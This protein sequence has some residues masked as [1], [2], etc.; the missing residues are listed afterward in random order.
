MLG[1]QQ[2]R[3]APAA[4]SEL[5]KNAHDAYAD[6][7]RAD[8]LRY[9]G[10]LAVRDD[11][12]GMSSADFRER[13]LT[14]GT[15]SR[16]GEQAV[17]LG[18]V[19][20]PILGEKG[21]GRLAIAVLGPQVLVVTR[22]EGSEEVTLSLINWDVFEEPGLNLDEIRFPLL[23]V[24]PSFSETD[25]VGLRDAA[26]E[27][28]LNLR[29]N[30][31]RRAR[32]AAAITAF[33]VDSVELALR[34]PG[35]N[36]R[37]SGGTAFFVSPV[38]PE[39]VDDIDREGETPD[40]VADLIGFANPIDRT[41][42][43]RASFWDWTGPGLK[44]D[45]VGSADFWE[46]AD[47]RDADHEIRGA[48]D[49]N[50]FFRGDIR[51]YTETHDHTIAPPKTVSGRLDCGPFAL[52]LGYMQGKATETKTDPQRFTEL[53]RKLD[54]FN[55]LY[56]YR[57]GIRMLPYG[58]STFD[59]LDIELNRS[60]G[61]SFYFFSYR[62]MFGY[63][64]ITKEANSGLQEK[65][66]REGFR[67][68]RAYRQFR[69]VLKH[70][71]VQ[72]AADYFREGSIGAEPFNKRRDELDR[73]A[74][75]RAAKEKRDAS[76]RKAFA[77]GL[78]GAL[79][80][81]RSGQA[82]RAVAKAVTVG[83]KALADASDEAAA[84]AAFEVAID[85]VASARGANSLGR[86]DVGLSEAALIDWESYLVAFA[87]LE[88]EVASATETLRDAAAAAIAR[89]RAAQPEPNGAAEP[90]V[91]VERIALVRAVGDGIARIRATGTEADAAI[92]RAGRRIR[93]LTDRLAAATEILASSDEAELSQRLAKVRST[94][95]LNVRLLASLGA[96]AD[97][98]DL[99][100]ADGT[101]L[102]PGDLSSAA[103]QELV[104]LREQAERDLELAQIGLAVEVVSHEF[105][106]TTAGIRGHLRDLGPWG[107]TNPDIEA[108]RAGLV[109]GFEHLDTY[110]GLFTP[111]ERRLQSQP[112][113]MSGAQ[114]QEFVGE[115]F[116]E[117]LVALGISLTATKAF[118]RHLFTGRPA[119]FY[120][121]FVNLID[122]ATFWLRERRQPRAIELDCQ[123]STLI[124]R[125]TGPGIAPG[126]RVFVFEP[127]FTRKPGGRG[128]GLY[129]SREVLLR[130]GWSIAVEG[131]NNGG[132]E[133]RIAPLREP[134]RD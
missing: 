133:F 38:V 130:N 10:L 39:L 88:G 32:T 109:T 8:F 23:T 25:L 66:G 122:N 68:N 40:L 129:I 127:G 123:G 15:E 64:A 72:L 59:W 36:L 62:R 18:K 116:S 100:S 22:A 49:D 26:A 98:V 27:S 35:P 57:D 101:F 95:D 9:R 110:L 3:G 33:P 58:R 4:I 31:E 96:A 44:R 105:E 76:E 118:E 16:L 21:I 54:R 126:D 17:P 56:I 50:G 70:F 11:G 81:L 134:G 37:L 78:A 94:V 5:F 85:A 121:V 114:I 13:W 120:P 113:E 42:A 79:R 2:I 84:A 71:F 82:A 51:V 65:A 67:E 6:Q 20:R 102:S 34:L 107:Q 75:A 87:E 60:K 92:E 111:L 103:D 80:R 74:R 89:T 86:P 52:R 24:G 91:D 46:D 7:V 53:S 112:V 45:L 132:A 117:R 30:S 99:Y 1:R 97:Q 61:A 93:S 106:E 115:L 12:I 29:I 69:D 119:V 124:V 77:R 19:Q 28:V 104:S 43:I 55:G 47:F 73:E 90:E 108:I 41:P 125:D 14:L 128:L 48:F 63:V 83:R 131:A